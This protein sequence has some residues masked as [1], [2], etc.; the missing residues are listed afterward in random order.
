MNPTEKEQLQAEKDSILEQQRQLQQQMAELD[1]KLGI[2]DMTMSQ[3]NMAFLTK[4]PKMNTGDN[5]SNYCER[6]KAYVEMTGLTTNIDLL[7]LQN[8]DNTTFTTLKASARELTNRQKSDVN[9]LCKAFSEAMYGEE[10][11]TLRNQS[12]GLS[13]AI[14]ISRCLLSTLD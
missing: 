4:P 11:F 10:S 2:P 5:F 13:N 14:F 3:R 1:T 6:F 8:V 12:D 9:L 7:F